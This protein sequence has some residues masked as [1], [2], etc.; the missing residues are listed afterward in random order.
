LAAALVGRGVGG[1]DGL[2][3]PLPVHEPLDLILVNDGADKRAR[4]ST[5]LDE[6]PDNR[7]A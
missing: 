1:V 3:G 5:V 7:A 2:R 6:R 4:Y